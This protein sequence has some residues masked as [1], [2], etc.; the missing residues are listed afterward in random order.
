MPADSLPADSRN[1]PAAAAPQDLLKPEDI[2]LACGAQTADIGTMLLSCSVF[3]GLAGADLQQV[4]RYVE[5]SAVAKGRA[6]FREGEAGD[7]MYVIYRGA[8][9]VWKRKTT[10]QRVDIA[11]LGGGRVFGEMAV[12]DGERRSATCFAEDDC[13]LLVLSKA[14][15]DR[16]IDELPRLGVEIVRCI[17]ISLSKNLR[18][19]V[20]K[21]VEQHA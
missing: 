15:L 17:A 13:Q 4:A 8:V 5:L 14:A 6:I 16:M 20:G 3:A 1:A 7:A 10:G 2:V 19:T 18:A 9:S 12:L 11:I 21:L